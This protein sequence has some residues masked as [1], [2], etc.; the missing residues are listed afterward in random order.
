MTKSAIQNLDP[1]KEAARPNSAPSRH[2]NSRTIH[3]LRSDYGNRALITGATSGMGKE[4]A[5]LL[6]AAGFDL[7]ITG[8][9]EHLLN[10][11]AT[12]LFDDFG[13]EAIPVV[14]DL[15]KK[16]EVESLF[17]ETDHLNI[18]IA[19]LNAGFGTSGKF[20]NSDLNQEINMLNVNARAVLMM[21]H[22]FAKKMKAQPQKGAIVLLSSIVAFQGAPNAAH[23]AATKAYVQSLGEGLGLELK[24][25]GIDIL[26]A[27]P[28]PVDSGFSER[29]NMQM[30]KTLNP[31]AVGKSIIKSI[32][33]KNT[34][35]PGFLTKFLV[36]N[37][38]M[39]PRW[40]KIRIM[41]MV[42]KGFTK[43]HAGRQV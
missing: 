36:Y 33:R 7:V 27:A 2:L 9:R 18:G 14:G 34:V 24:A 5:I 3:R 1:K 4:M 41:G 35:F 11:L 8:R 10:K 42:M 25:D 6:G 26:C 20:L 31:A 16:A 13:V 43:H 37:L 22:H 21:I 15:S 12:Q 28:G 23:Y 17:R 29:A 30:G 32:G 39:T 19:I 40:G 38:R